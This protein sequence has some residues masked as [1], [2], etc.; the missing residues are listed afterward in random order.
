[1]ST[2]TKQ[3][4]APIPLRA[5]LDQRLTGHHFRVLA[6]VAAHDRLG[7]N[8]NGCWASQDR[9][10]A[11]LG[12]GKSRIS[13]GLSDLRD[14]G[15][16]ASE[17]NPQKRWYRVHR[18]IYSSDDERFWT[19]KS[20]AKE[21]NSFTKSVSMEDNSFSKS[22]AKTGVNQFPPPPTNVERKQ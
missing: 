17:L 1:V 18:V 20:V 7:K 11:L 5:V 10:A 15:Y 6:L 9:L 14:Y 21:N 16:I 3:R 8:G 19:S 12:C 4:F 13:K 2:A 22:V